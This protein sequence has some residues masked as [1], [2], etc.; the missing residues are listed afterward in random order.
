M[1]DKAPVADG[2]LLALDDGF[3]YG[4]RRSEKEIWEASFGSYGIDPKKG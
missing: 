3:G 1:V 4:R 2:I